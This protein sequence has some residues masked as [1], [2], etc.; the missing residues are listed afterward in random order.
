MA[1]GRRQHVGTAGEGG[2]LS[3]RLHIR[4][5]RDN[6]GEEVGG[7]LGVGGQLHEQLVVCLR[8]SE[9]V[10]NLLILDELAAVGG[11]HAVG[12]EDEILH[13]LDDLPAV[14]APRRAL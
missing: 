2:G 12:L 7:S 9:G 5:G 4:L 1:S 10:A 11:L 3:S 8:L 6:A 13:R 14:S